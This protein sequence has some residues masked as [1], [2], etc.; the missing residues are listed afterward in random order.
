MK[1]G[2]REANQSFSKAI[3][4]VKSGRRIVLTERGKPIAVISPLSESESEEAAIERMRDEGILLA[5]TDSRPMDAWKPV[6]TRGR[7][8]TD[9]LREERDER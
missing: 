8:T 6:R 3:Q 7:S 5:A 9:L 4:I 2:L 1:M